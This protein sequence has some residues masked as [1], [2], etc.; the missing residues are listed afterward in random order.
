M[1][2]EEEWGHL[3]DREPD[4][5]RK[6]RTKICIC[7]DHFRYACN[8]QFVTLQTCPVHQKLIPL[9]DHLI[10]CCKYCIKRRELGEGW[11]PEVALSH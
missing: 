1:I 4:Q 6:K 8:V 7:C 5:L 3:N 10:K 9:G 2:E 11:C